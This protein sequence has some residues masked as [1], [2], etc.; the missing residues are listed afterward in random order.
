[1]R[2]V[3]WSNIRL[4]WHPWWNHQRAWKHLR[5]QPAFSHSTVNLLQWA[6]AMASGISER[7]IRDW[8]CS[9][10]RSDESVVLSTGTSVKLTTRIFF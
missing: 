5:E 2:L 9:V 8:I 6:E 1:M 10:N 3:H 4:R 7:S